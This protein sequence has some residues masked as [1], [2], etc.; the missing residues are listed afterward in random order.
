MWSFSPNANQVFAIA[1]R[2]AHAT[3]RGK[4]TAAAA[5][6]SSA[7]KGAPEGCGCSPQDSECTVASSFTVP[8]LLF[9]IP[10]TISRVE[11][12]ILVLVCKTA[13][14]SNFLLFVLL[15]TLRAVVNQALPPLPQR[16]RPYQTR[17]GVEATPTCLSPPLFALYLCVL[18]L[19]K[20]QS[21]RWIVAQEQGIC[22]HN[23]LN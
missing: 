13:M 19:Q 2:Y 11:L 23:S 10:Q 5:E 4:I 9:D 7:E 15:S 16:S 21:Q 18:F 1:S 6:R 14:Y 12:T 8:I 22:L 20:T 17:L 3:A